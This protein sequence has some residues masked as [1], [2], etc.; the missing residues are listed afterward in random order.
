MRLRWLLLIADVIW[1]ALGGLG[2]VSWAV[3]FPV[4]VA[5]ALIAGTRLLIDLEKPRERQPC[6]VKPSTAKV[7]DKQAE[8]L[9][10]KLQESLSRGVAVA[11]PVKG[12]FRRGEEG[13]WSC[14][15]PDCDPAYSCQRGRKNPDGSI[16]VITPVQ[17]QEPLPVLGID[18]P[19]G[20]YEPDG[21]A[22]LSAALL[23]FIWDQ[24]KEAEVHRIGPQMAWHVSPEWLEEVARIRAP[25]GKP[26]WSPRK[27][28]VPPGKLHTEFLFGYPVVTGDA[29]GVPELREL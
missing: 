9:R 25:D 1:T 24:V 29:F 27:R 5:L 17:K 2:V 22:E 20:E 11:L 23:E 18:V 16:S 15:H 21:Q 10:A 8:E 14:G 12:P 3:A 26:A 28:V 13:Y 4:L 7:T 19:D 6:E